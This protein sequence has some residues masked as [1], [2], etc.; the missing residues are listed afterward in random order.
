LYD[1]H[2]WG[3]HMSATDPDALLTLD[4][5]EVKEGFARNAHQSGK[6]LL[7]VAAS[8][9]A[10]EWYAEGREVVVHNPHSWPVGGVVTVEYARS[11]QPVDPRSGQSLPERVLKL[12]ASQVT[13]E[14]PLLEPLP[15]NAYRRFPLVPRG[16]SP[17]G[18]APQ[19]VQGDGPLA[20][21]NEY[22]RVTID[23][24]R[25]CATSL[26]DRRT[27]REYVDGTDQFGLGQFV[28]AN[29]GEGTRLISNQADLPPGNPRLDATF[30]LQAAERE[31][32]PYGSTVRLNGL[33]EGGELTVEW[34]LRRGSRYLDLGYRYQKEERRAKEAVYVA[35]PLDIPGARVRSDNQTGWIDWERDALPGA[36]QEWLPLQTGIL[37]D[38]GGEIAHIASPDVPLFCVRD[39]VLGRWPRDL[40]LTGGRL[41]S[42]VLNNYWHTNY[43]GT[44]GGETTWRYRLA[45]GEDISEASA[46]RAGWEVR[47]PAYAH[48]MSHQDFRRA[49]EPYAD[50]SGGR[51]AV[52]QSEGDDIVL[53][54][55]RPA[56]GGAGYLARFQDTGG[57]GGTVTLEIPGRPVARAW[58][59][60]LLGGGAEEVP[61]AAGTVSVDLPA[62]GLATVRFELA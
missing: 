62:W 50:P 15:G 22:L 60:D 13:A 16:S 12:T 31:D 36:C 57:A 48:R 1:E 14:L 17:A 42:Y 34:T 38:A 35:F 7:H 9:H 55:L 51:L 30:R 29:G 56:P 26:V 61:V 18:P 25:G 11:E 54:S 27:G 40:D 3:A 33:V 39:V 45:A 19:A 53:Q 37:V 44:Q 32:Y 49:R 20:I 23:P 4:Q 10:L 43:K 46:Y 59:T 24:Q 28:Y 52:V 41:F 2:T 8:R 21:E 5:W 58:R 6:R 47:R